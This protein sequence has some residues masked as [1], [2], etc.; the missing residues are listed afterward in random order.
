MM[1][2]KIKIMGS[3]QIKMMMMMMMMIIMMDED[4]NDYVRNEIYL[5]KYKDDDEKKIKLMVSIQI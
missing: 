5:G 2:N 4:D 3:I 1:K